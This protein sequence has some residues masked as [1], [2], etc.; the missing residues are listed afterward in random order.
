MRA[1]LLVVKAFVTALATVDC[2]WRTHRA[3]VS[4]RV[5]G[6][7]RG[8]ARA[9]GP[10]V[11]LLRTA[12]RLLVGACAQAESRF[13][14]FGLRAGEGDVRCVAVRDV[15]LLGVL[16]EFVEPEGGAEVALTAPRLV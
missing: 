7:R 12:D 4:A 14:L 1:S 3:H 16:C 13:E 6:Q 8:P 15:A 9:C 5:G 10:R 2:S 11:R